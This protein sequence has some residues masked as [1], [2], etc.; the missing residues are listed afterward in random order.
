MIQSKLKEVRRKCL[1]SE[2]I[3]ESGLRELESAAQA[4]LEPGGTVSTEYGTVQMIYDKPVEFFVRRK[5]EGAEPFKHK[6]KLMQ[7]V[8]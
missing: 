7:E 8:E 1:E 6:L 4:H 2:G 3:T 5:A